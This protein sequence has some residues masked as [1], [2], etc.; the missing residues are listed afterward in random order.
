M[1][2]VEYKNKPDAS[3]LHQIWEMRE[4]LSEERCVYGSYSNEHKWR[5]I[6]DLEMA[7]RIGRTTIVNVITYEDYLLEKI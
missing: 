3:H 4:D 2:Y 1:I 7:Q 5:A 6:F